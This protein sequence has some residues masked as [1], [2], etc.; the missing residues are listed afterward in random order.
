[1]E[2]KKRSHWVLGIFYFNLK[3]ERFIVPEK[4]PG[5]GITT[6]FAHPYTL[7]IGALSLLIIFLASTRP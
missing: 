3:D 1:M 5:M 6:N 4:V 2:T 7:L